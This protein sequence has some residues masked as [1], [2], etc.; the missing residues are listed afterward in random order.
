MRK[1]IFVLG[2]IV[3]LGGEA[4]GTV[5][6]ALKAPRYLVLSGLNKCLLIEKQDGRDTLCWPLKS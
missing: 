3:L 1:E 6:P 5:L 4:M 2:L